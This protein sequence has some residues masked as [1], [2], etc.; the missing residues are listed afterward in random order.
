MK[1]IINQPFGVGDILFLS[2]LVA[3]LDI[4]HAVWPVVD[5]YYWIKDYI[6][7]DNL[8]FVKESEFNSLN[9][10]DYVEVPLQ[11]AHSLVPQAEDCMQAKYMLLHADPELWRTITFNRN[12]EKENQLKQYLNISPNDKFIFVNNNFAGPEYNYKVD[13]KLDTDLKIIYQEYI[14]GFT[15]LDWCGV[16]E[17]AKEI[18]TVITSLF[19]VIEALNLEN[20]SLHLYPRKPLDK[21]L[22]PIKTLISNKWICYE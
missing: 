8:T 22:S 15:L 7:M 6:S 13:I 18:H 20:T 4:E 12:S 11:H 16:L 1:V 3:N 5:H 21:D 17:Q 2:P 9:Y 14:E 19:F 10:K